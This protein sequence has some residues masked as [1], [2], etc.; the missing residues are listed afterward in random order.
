MRL[1]TPTVNGPMLVNDLDPFVGPLLMKCGEFSRGEA[2]LMRGI[3]KPGWV[4]AD[5]GAN[6]GAHTLLLSRLVGPTGTVYAFE[7][8]RLLFQMLCANVA[9]NSMDNVMAQ[10]CAIGAEA[11]EIRIRSMDQNIRQNFGGTALALLEGGDEP[12]QIK[13]F[14]VPCNFLKIDVEGME[15]EVLKGAADMIRE[16]KPFIFVE[17]ETEER[18]LELIDTVWSLGYEPRWWITPLFDP[19]NPKGCKENIFGQH[20]STFNMACQPI[21]MPGFESMEIADCGHET[22]MERWRVQREKAAA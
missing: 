15:T 21:G 3:V 8:Q 17:N 10:Q 4:V 6:I 18:A 22:L 16:Y 13:P 20:V 5:I 14:D 12:V 7:P 2:E 19:D 11:R 1:I 9:L